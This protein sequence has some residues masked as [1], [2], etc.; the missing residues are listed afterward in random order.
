MAV[1]SNGNGA[2]ATPRAICEN[3]KKYKFCSFGLDCKY[4]HGKDAP[5]KDINTLLHEL[6]QMG[7]MHTKGQYH[8]LLCGNTSP[9]PMLTAKVGETEA[10]RYCSVCGN[11][12]YYPHVQLIVL[13]ILEEAGTDYMEYRRQIVA[14]HSRLPHILMAP[15]MYEAHRWATSRYAW[16][17]TGPQHAEAMLSIMFDKQPKSKRM[18]SMGSGTGYIE[19]VFHNAAKGL[20]KALAINAYDRQDPIRRRIKFDVEVQQGDV[21]NLKAFGDMS[22]AI[23]MLCWPPFGSQQGEE[24]TMAFDA[25]NQFAEQGGQQL[26][27]IGD[28]NAT[29]DWRFHEKLA[30]HWK[31]HEETFQLP[32][33]D[34]WVPQHMGLIY[35]GFDSIGLYSIRDV[36]LKL[37]PRVWTQIA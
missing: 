31:L 33:L 30:S 9:E 19:H 25:V 27:Y 13:K 32:K 10:Y 22:D 14:Y 8:C 36:P 16:S 28:V 23:L 17:L 7:L 15:F 24:S 34:V 20:G 12:Y 37:E 4:E 2:A 5:E 6:I 11:F 21:S 26:I 35:A 3:W 29:G 1:L 18:F